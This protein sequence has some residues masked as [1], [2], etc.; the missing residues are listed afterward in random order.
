[1]S[2]FIKIGGVQYPASITGRLRDT[3]WND[4]QTKCIKLQ[5]TYAN[6]AALF[7]D[8]VQWSILQENTRDIEKLDENGELVIETVT[9]FEEYDNSEYNLAGDITDHKDGF[10]TVK[11]GKLTELESVLELLLGGN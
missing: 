7:V 6:A 11:M 9:E 8:N 10:V 2:T 5:L 3:D 1:M 4:R